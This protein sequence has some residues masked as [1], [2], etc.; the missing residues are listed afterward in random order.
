M[1]FDGYAI[2]VVDPAEIFQHLVACK[3]GRLTRHALHHVAIAAK[4]VHV[5]IENLESRPIE[6]L[7]QPASSERHADAIT[8]TL[9]E[10]PGGGLDAR[11]D[12][13]L[14]VAGAFAIELP[15][16]FDIVETDSG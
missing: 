6:M 9:A 11:R 13:V 3:R 8:A 7:R 14:G 1:A 4:C 2:A 10:W 12:A 15:E 16:F 5:V